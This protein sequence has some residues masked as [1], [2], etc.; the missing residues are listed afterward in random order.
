MSAKQF[1][2]YD[3]W[4]MEVLTCPICGWAGTAEQ[5]SVNYHD[6]LMES[7]CPICPW[8]DCPTLAIVRFPT[9]EEMEANIDKLSDEQKASLW[10]RKRFLAEVERT[11]LK[12]PDELPDL[13]APEIVIDWDL[14]TADDGNK[15][16]DIRYGDQILWSE[17]AVYEGAN[18]FA[19]VVDILKRKYGKRLV[20]VIP[21]DASSLYL[22]GDDLQTIDT[23][24]VARAQIR[25]LPKR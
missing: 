4:K 14:R 22:Y 6:G 3:D 9:L 25:S 16:T 17:W 8:P 10:E 2:Y 18:R 11:S 5:G 21:T 19:E 23:V 20:D 1:F 12:S 7:S 13:P 15:W 24:K